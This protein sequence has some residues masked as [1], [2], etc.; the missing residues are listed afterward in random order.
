[1]PTTATNE[2][3]RRAYKAGSLVLHPDKNPSPNA[4]AIFVAFKEAYTVL[5]DG[6][7]R[8][9]Y[10]RFGIDILRQKTD[11]VVP[12]IVGNFVNPFHFPT[13]IPLMNF[14]HSF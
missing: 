8:E 1:V 4:E 5:N 10:N 12:F 2:E 7:L 13:S 6:V 9:R 14:L 11:D 3:I